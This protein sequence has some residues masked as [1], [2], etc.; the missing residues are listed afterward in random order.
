MLLLSYTIGTM[1]ALAHASKKLVINFA[2]SLGGSSAPLAEYV[3]ASNQSHHNRIKRISLD[4]CTLPNSWSIIHPRFD[5]TVFEL[6]VWKAGVPNIIRFSINATGSATYSTPQQIAAELQAALN[7]AT[8][9][10]AI[11]WSVVFTAGTG[12]LT[13]TI[14]SGGVGEIFHWNS[15]PEP[16]TRFIN[17]SLFV[18]GYF[19]QSVSVRSPVDVQISKAAASVTG[20]IMDVQPIKSVFITIANTTSGAEMDSSRA[21]GSFVV[22]V[23]ANH[24]FHT[25]YNSGTDFE[26]VVYFHDFSYADRNLSIR[27]TDRSGQL[28]PFTGGEVEMIIDV[29]TRDAKR[30]RPADHKSPSLAFH[31]E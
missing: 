7:V 25:T 24:G 1:S 12:A 26:N 10:L 27:V 30:P 28:I 29:E 20:F 14:T 13:T 2:A 18:T 8:A 15:E 16:T 9:S 11:T 3:Q 31:L 17:R 19:F 22:P 23:R 4:Y 5:N 21:H 6:T